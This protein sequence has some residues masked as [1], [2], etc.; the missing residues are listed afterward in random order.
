M[1][2][3]RSSKIALLENVPLF[4][5]LS[6]KQLQDIARLADEIDVPAG[7]R[8]ATAGESGQELFVIIEGSAVVKAPK[9]RVVRLGPGEFFGEMSLLDGGPRSATVE[10]AT[11]MRLLVVGRREFWELLKIAPPLALKIMGTLSRRV[12]DVEA[13]ISM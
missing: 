6:R 10:A 1:V 9:G 11:G 5:N 13:S 7:K 8:L 4:G 3:G 2:F 12:R